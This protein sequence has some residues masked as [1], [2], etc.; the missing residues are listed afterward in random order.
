[1]EA[2]KGLE[3]LLAAMRLLRDAGSTIELRLAGS[4]PELDRLRQEFE[5]LPLSSIESGFIPHERAIAEFGDAALVVAPY[6]EATQSGVISAAFGNGRPVVASAVG[7][8]PDFVIHGKNGLLVPPND[9]R[10]LADTLRTVLN[11]RA[12][13]ESLSNGA[14]LS[15]E[16]DLGW[17]IFSDK[18]IRCAETIL[19]GG[20]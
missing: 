10:A 18:V 2:Y 12:L 13:L 3:V 19:G 8:I 9:P 20:G 15:A 1:M 4:G 16:T 11:D 6:I 17:G 5:A 7:G 14:R